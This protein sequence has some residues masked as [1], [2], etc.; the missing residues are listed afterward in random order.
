M[1]KIILWQISERSQI[2]FEVAETREQ[3]GSQFFE[4]AD[5]ELNQE[6]ADLRAVAGL[7]V[8]GIY[9]M[10]LHAK[11]NDSLFCEI[12][13]NTEAGLNRIKNA[14]GN[15]LSDTYKRAKHQQN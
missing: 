15:I 12:D 5:K 8:G 14:I 3:V 11:S 9:Y 10:V 1:Q 4:L 7:L 13:I 6:K 2:M